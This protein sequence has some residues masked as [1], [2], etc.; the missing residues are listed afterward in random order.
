VMDRRLAAIRSEAERERRQQEYAAFLARQPVYH[1]VKFGEALSSIAEQY[2]LSPDSLKM[3]NGLT[4]DRIKA[5]QR[6]LV[7]P[8]L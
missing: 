7:R 2:G 5:G 1:D 3:L 4:D 6:L 8:G